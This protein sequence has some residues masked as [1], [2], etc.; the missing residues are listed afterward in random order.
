MNEDAKNNRKTKVDT[1]ILRSSKPS[2]ATV[3]VSSANESAKEDELRSAIR[4]AE[5]LR[6]IIKQ[7]QSS[8]SSVASPSSNSNLSTPKTLNTRTKNPRKIST[9]SSS[10]SLVVPTSKRR[11]TNRKVKYSEDEK[12]ENE[13]SDDDDQQEQTLK[14]DTRSKK[15]K[16]VDEKE[17]KTGD[18]SNK[19]AK[20]DDDSRKRVENEENG[21][22]NETEGALS[23]DTNSL[24][25]SAAES[26]FITD[27]NYGIVTVCIKE[28][29]TPEGFFKRREF[30]K[31]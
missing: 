14:R 12:Y 11:M 30:S 22:N 1:K 15:L 26:V 3:A 5:G 29:P 7:N 2:T 23:D 10:S 31:K 4:V 6:P 17:T 27:V 19:T 8:N 13:T 28:C 21:A 25:S 18:L 16:L 20:T 24:I 9:S